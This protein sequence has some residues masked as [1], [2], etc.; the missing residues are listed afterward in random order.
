MSL[1]VQKSNKIFYRY[2]ELHK[3]NVLIRMTLIYNLI[4]KLL[5]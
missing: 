2:Y 5:I 1:D 3:I 4:V